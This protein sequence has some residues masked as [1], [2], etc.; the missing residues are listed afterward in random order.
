MNKEEIKA[1]IIDILN[2]AKITTAE[3]KE[4]LKDLNKTIDGAL[5]KIP[6]NIKGE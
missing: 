3:C 1:Q 2:D 4:I 5:G 6:F